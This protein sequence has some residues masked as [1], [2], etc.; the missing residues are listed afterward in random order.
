MPV[1]VTVQD[2]WTEGPY[3]ARRITVTGDNSY[4]NAGSGDHGEPLTPATL[5]FDLK[6][7]Y[8]L[9][10]GP[11]QKSDGTSAFPVSYNR[12]TSEVRY[13][14]SNGTTDLIPVGSGVDLTTYSFEAIVV[15]KGSNLVFAAPGANI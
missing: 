3:T 10:L 5:G 8:F 4:R 12:A 13:Y 14:K 9:P 6:L 15:G 11:A 7:A 2:Q 1:T